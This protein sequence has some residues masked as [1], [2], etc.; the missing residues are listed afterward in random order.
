MT[1]FVLLALW[2]VMITGWGN[3]L[4]LYSCGTSGKKPD[5]GVTLK[6]LVAAIVA[7]ALGTLC[8]SFIQSA[9]QSYARLGL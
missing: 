3:V 2:T 6:S 1:H 8:H 4:Y 9:L 7:L 5:Y